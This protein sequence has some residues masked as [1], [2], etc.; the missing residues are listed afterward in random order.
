MGWVWY[1]IGDPFCHLLHQLFE[2]HL[3]GAYKTFQIRFGRSTVRQISKP[4]KQ[5]GTQVCRDV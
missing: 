4:L 2:G 1:F 3:V 5:F